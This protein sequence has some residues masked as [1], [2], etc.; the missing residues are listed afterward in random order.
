[1]SFARG[2]RILRR[3][4]DAIANQSEQS[5]P[6]QLLDAYAGMA[7]CHGALRVT[8]EGLVLEFQGRDGF[9]N[10][11]KGGVQDVTIPWADVVDLKLQS[12]WFVTRLLLTVRSMKWL[13]GVPGANGCQVRM[14][15]ERRNRLLARQV[16]F[17]VNLRLCERELKQ[18][19]ARPAS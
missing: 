14:K 13:A 19:A 1:M 3:M 18:A 7:D 15:V 11:L 12:N 4:S 8:A 16:A 2:A 10:M 17:A 9:L 5:V 6:V